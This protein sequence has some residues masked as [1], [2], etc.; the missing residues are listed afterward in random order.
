MKNK[1][2]QQP[3]TWLPLYPFNIYI[4][5]KTLKHMLS[6]KENKK[7]QFP[8]FNG[9]SNFRSVFALSKEDY[10]VLVNYKVLY[11]QVVFP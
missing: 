6:K 7:C 1:I 2:S 11:L 4:T 3:K 5:F 9:G 10:E 8:F